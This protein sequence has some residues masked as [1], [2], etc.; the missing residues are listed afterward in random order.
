ME[1]N[2]RFGFNLVLI[3]LILALLYMFLLDVNYVGLK[4]LINNLIKYKRSQKKTKE[5]LLTQISQKLINIQVHS[6]TVELPKGRE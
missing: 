2:F 6:T 4:T 5:L 3:L 1:D